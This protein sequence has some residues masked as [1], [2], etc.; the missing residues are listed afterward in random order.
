MGTVGPYQLGD[1]L[2]LVCMVRGG[3][4]APRVYWTRDGEV[5]DDRMDKTTAVDQQQVGMQAE[6]WRSGAPLS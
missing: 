1:P 3:D 6:M 2:I 5:W 4:P